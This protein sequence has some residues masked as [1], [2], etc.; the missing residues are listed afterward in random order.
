MP[1]PIDWAA[2]TYGKV[3]HWGLILFLSF[4]FVAVGLV[5]WRGVEQYRKNI[6]R[7]IQRTPENP[8]LQTPPRQQNK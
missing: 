2:W 8:R 3:G 7:A 6:L 1:D 5:W 4:M